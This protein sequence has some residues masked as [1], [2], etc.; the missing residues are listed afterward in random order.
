MGVANTKKNFAKIP[1]KEKLIRGGLVEKIM[2]TT[3]A[4]KDPDSEVKVDLIVSPKNF[5]ITTR[6]I[7][8]KIEEI[9]IEKTDLQPKQRS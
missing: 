7:P 1:K 6:K 5:A 3:Y 2:G 4:D 8:L 9:P